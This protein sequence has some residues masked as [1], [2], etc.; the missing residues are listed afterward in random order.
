MAALGC[1]LLLVLPLVGLTIGG[2]L[3]GPTGMAWGA[4][5][6]LAAALAISGVAGGALVKASRRR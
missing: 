6:G 1:I 5:V 3:A 4:G 2:L